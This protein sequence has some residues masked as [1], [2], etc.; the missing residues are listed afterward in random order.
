[1]FVIRRESSIELRVDNSNDVVSSDADSS[2]NFDVSSNNL[3]IAGVADAYRSSLIADQ[4]F[5]NF[6]GCLVQVVYNNQQLDLTQTVARSQASLKASKCFKSQVR[7]PLLSM[8]D[9]KDLQN[10]VLVNRYSQIIKQKSTNNLI[11]NTL[12]NEEC[13]L[14]RTYDTSQLKPVGLRFG[15]SKHSRLEV[16]EEFPIKITTFVSFK[17]RTLQS[18]GLMFYASDAQ[19]EDFISVW[20]EEGSVNYAFDCGSGF[21][22]IKSK[23]QYSDGR[24]HTLTIR[25][26][27][28]VGTLFISDRTNTSVV[29]TIESKS[30][31]DSSSLSVVEPYYFGNMPESDKSQLTSAQSDL[32]VTE[33]FVGCMSDFNIAYRT[34]KSNLERVDLMNCSNNHESGIFFTGESTTSFASLPNYISLSEPFELS[35]E[36]K[37]RTKNGVLLYLGNATELEPKTNFAL[38][39]FVDGELVYKVVLDGQENVVRYLPEKARNELCNS[40]WIR[41]K[42]K[43]TEKGLISLELKGSEST[44]SFSSDLS[45]LTAKITINSAV[46]V[47]GLPEKALYSEITQSSESFVGC[48]RDFT[49]RR[50]KA[51]GHITKVLLDM[52]LENGV[53]SYCPLK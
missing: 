48:V 14:S 7:S 32:I 45:K 4:P 31:G 44:N 36:V 35:F 16:N 18:D 21:M 43:T 24:Y 41:I 47:G 29:E 19:F 52:S 46:Y 38:L 40:S 33:P 28:Q 25:R 1:M 12:S 9:F 10:T 49:M 11:D 15:L 23:K 30:E 8:P 27:K 53:L 42:L 13:S 3:F 26:D 20:L 17:F 39:E 22:H 34:L 50:N 51:G 37:S 5:T 6:E 2:D